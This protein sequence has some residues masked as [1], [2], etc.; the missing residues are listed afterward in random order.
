MKVYDRSF[1]FSRFRCDW[2]E[3]TKV[4]VESE[5]AGPNE[6]SKNYHDGKTVK[7]VTVRT[8]YLMWNLI[9]K[10]EAG[11]WRPEWRKSVPN[12]KNAKFKGLERGSLLACLSDRK[13]DH[14]G[15]GLSNNAER[16]R[17]DWFRGTLLPSQDVLVEHHGRL[18]LIL[19]AM[20][21][22]WRIL[23]NKRICLLSYF[24][25]ISSWRM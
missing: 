4:G 15:F 20:E 3:Q 17:G 12:W 23:N 6:C 25:K 7:E 11:I 13:K 2:F 18:D 22:H 21:S 10:E 16:K 1:N 19:I 9:D 5:T 14:N 24:R 8:W